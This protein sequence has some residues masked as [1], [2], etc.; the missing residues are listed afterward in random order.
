MREGGKGQNVLV[1]SLPGKKHNRFTSG[2]CPKMKSALMQADHSNDHGG[3]S[4]VR[5]L[6]GNRGASF[7]YSQFDGSPY[8]V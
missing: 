2:Y 1:S 3:A 4:Y 5:S 6:E 7:C 8:L